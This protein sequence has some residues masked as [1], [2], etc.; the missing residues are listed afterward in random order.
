MKRHPVLSV[1]FTENIKS[2]RAQVSYDTLNSYFDDLAATLAD[3]TISNIINCDETDF[4]DDPASVKVVVRR[5]GKHVDRVID[6]SKTS[7]SVTIVGA[8]NGSMLPP[9]TVYKSKHYI[10]QIY[11]TCT[12]RGLPGAAYNRNVTGWLDSTM[13]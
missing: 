9:Y 13:F 1:R 3:V 8:A 12:D 4:T 10:L 6:S 2:V 5:G 7:I 11:P